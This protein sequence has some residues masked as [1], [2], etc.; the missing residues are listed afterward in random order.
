MY[1]ITRPTTT[2][3]YSEEHQNQTI[4]FSFVARSE[5]DD[6]ELIELFPKVKCRDFLNDVIKA[7]HEKI[8]VSVFGF[9]FDGSKLALNPNYTQLLVTLDSQSEIE[10]F[11]SNF[12]LLQHIEGDNRFHYQSTI[13]VINNPN[14][15]HAEYLITGS[16]WWQESPW[17]ISL[18][19]WLLRLMTYPTFASTPVE[20][21]QNLIKLSNPNIELQ[22]LNLV[23]EKL[24]K[25]LW[26]NLKKQSS[27][28]EYDKMLNAGIHTF[29]NYTGIIGYLQTVPLEKI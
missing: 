10:F 6:N 25:L 1:K 23:Q 11:Q 14:P 16:A 29:H 9:S 17:R 26:G 8:P 19:T 21:I 7:N 3:R 24:N 12:H 4:K 2:P 15:N 20:W 22:R 13:K 27:N 18:Y 5:H 28:A